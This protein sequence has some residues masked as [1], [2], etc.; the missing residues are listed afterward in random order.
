MH[1]MRMMIAGKTYRILEVELYLTGPGHLDPFTHCSNVQKECGKW[2]FHR[3]GNGGYRSGSF[4]GLDISIGQ[5]KY[6]GGLLIRTIIR[7]SDGHVIT[8]PSLCVDHILEQCGAK[9]INE[10]VDEKFDG[11]INI[12]TCPFLKIKIDPEWTPQT[13][14]GGDEKIYLSPRF[15]L[16]PNKEGEKDFVWWYLYRPYRFVRLPRLFSKA[17]I[18][19]ALGFY[20]TS[21]ESL[22]ARQITQI[23]GG[24]LSATEKYI[25]LY[26]EGIQKGDDMLKEHFGSKLSP[27]NW[28][29]G[30]GAVS[31]LELSSSE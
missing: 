18:N 4:K 31:N 15:G 21:A 24:T 20:A 11:D 12:E 27:D 26:V 5:N 6:I 8:G 30:Y 13:I 9:T 19:T 2:Y 28:C 25:S 10:L 16:H 3:M 23:I 22:S 17:R 1:G 7:E 29:K 14:K